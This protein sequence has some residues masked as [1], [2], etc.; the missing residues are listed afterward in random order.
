MKLAQTILMSDKKIIVVSSTLIFEFKFDWMFDKIITVYA[1]AET[2][3]KRMSDFRKYSR[4]KIDMVMKLHMPIGEKAK[5]S[6]FFIDGDVDR[7]TT[8]RNIFKLINRK[9]EKDF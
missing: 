3:A 5:K 6:D 4:E 8:I 1:S 9:I 7:E 2:Q